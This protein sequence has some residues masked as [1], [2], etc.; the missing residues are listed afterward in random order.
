MIF[1][2]NHWKTNEKLTC[3]KIL[4]SNPMSNHE[5]P[6]KNHC[7]TLKNQGNPF[8]NL[9][10][11]AFTKPCRIP[12]GNTNSNTSGN[13]STLNA[14]APS[15]IFWFLPGT[16]KKTKYTWISRRDEKAL[17]EAFLDEFLDAVS[18]AFP[19]ALERFLRTPR[20]KPIGIPKGDRERDP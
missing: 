9:L 7:K 12:F 2:E 1:I 8:R 3:L 20:G 10:R 15:K 18:V 11:N 5:K 17:L 4:N 19:L 6:L 16:E 13:S 14:F